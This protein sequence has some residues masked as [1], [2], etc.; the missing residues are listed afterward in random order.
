MNSPHS[1]AWG[2]SARY[3]RVP[4]V[5]AVVLAVA[6]L[7]L[8]VVGAGVT[9]KGAGMAFPDWPTSNGALV[10]PTGWWQG[11]KT[12]WEHGHRLLGWTVGMLAIVSA[13]CSWRRGP[14]LRT[15]ACATLLAIVIQGVL[16]G[17]RV[18]AVSTPLAMVH[19]IWGQ[20]CF[21]L[22]C[23]VALRTSSGWLE[24]GSAVEVRGSGLFQRGALVGTICAFLQ[25]VFGAA[26]RHFGVREALIAHVLWAVVVILVLGWVVMWALEQYPQ[27]ELLTK[28]GRALAVLIGMQMILGGLA[29]LVTVMGGEWPTMLRWAA[30][31]AHVAVGAMLLACSLLMTLSSHRLLRPGADRARAAATAVVTTP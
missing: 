19:G 31:S 9:S 1:D 3:Q 2:D 26:W 29:F 22:A 14:T 4:H 17:L 7:P 5:V 21:C 16:G 6:L 10:N 25:L 8:I 24:S 18:R 15:L 23:V 27:L 28:F 13:A 30:P 20:V 12:L 11:E